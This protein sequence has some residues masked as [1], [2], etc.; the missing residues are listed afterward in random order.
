MQDDDRRR[1]AGRAGCAAA[2]V[3]W[4]RA[5][6]RRRVAADAHAAAASRPIRLPRHLS[7]IL[8]ESALSVTMLI[9]IDS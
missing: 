9:D 8:L 3:D 5:P 7:E 2:A 1:W 4:R 6:L